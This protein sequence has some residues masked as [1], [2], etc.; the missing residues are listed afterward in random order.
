[1]SENH[2]SSISVLKKIAKEVK[3]KIKIIFD[4]GVRS[5]EDIF[6]AI[7]LGADLVM[8]GRPFFMAVAGGEREGVKT[9]I[10]QYKNELVKIMLLTGAKDIS[11]ITEDMVIL[12]QYFNEVEETQFKSSNYFSQ[13]N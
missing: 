13:E 5:G 7:A 11:S 4:G 3:G 12:P 2:P 9:L 8:I 6:K 10:D 1:M